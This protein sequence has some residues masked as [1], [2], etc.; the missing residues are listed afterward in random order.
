LLGTIAYNNT[1]PKT[2]DLVSTGKI[3]LDQFI[4]AK[5]GLDDLIDK[6]FDTLIHHNETAVKILVSPTGKGL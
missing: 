5:I 6:G 2:I 1:H 4:T 3:K